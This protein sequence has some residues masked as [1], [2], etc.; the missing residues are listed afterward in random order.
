MQVSESID[1]KTLR[2]DM[3]QQIVNLCELGFEFSTFLESTDEDTL[4]EAVRTQSIKRTRKLLSSFERLRQF[5]KTVVFTKSTNLESIKVPMVEYPLEEKD[6]VKMITLPIKKYLEKFEKDLNNYYSEID[7]LLQLTQQTPYTLIKFLN[8]LES[9]EVYIYD[10]VNFS[11]QVFYAKLKPY[12]YS[13]RAEIR[14][15]VIKVIDW[16]LEQLEELALIIRKDGLPLNSYN[17]IIAGIILTLKSIIPTQCLKE[18]VKYK[19][20][21]NYLSLNYLL[22]DIAEHKIELTN[23]N[24][25]I[26]A[27]KIE[28][29]NNPPFK[30]EFKGLSKQ[31]I[32]H[33]FIFPQK[34]DEDVFWDIF[35]SS[36]IQRAG[37]ITEIKD[38]AKA[39]G[40]EVII[41]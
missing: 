30:E 33:S 17:K 1:W 9:F 28:T 23:I 3:P 6:E 18:L 39:K 24:G 34:Q 15:I 35:L 41:G 14:D 16:K 12:E 32:E 11:K 2:N 8:I 13:R 10:V 25:E 40:G 36:V 21:K 29:A 19:I 5:F 37:L 20:N 26:L 7:K 4:F 38:D 31:D 22:R 27:S